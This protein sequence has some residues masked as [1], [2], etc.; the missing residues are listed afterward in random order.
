M[1]LPHSISPELLTDFIEL[2]TAQTGLAIRDQ[3]RITLSRKIWTRMNRLGITSPQFYYRLLSIGAGQNNQEWQEFVLLLTNI[4]SYFFRDRGQFSLLR[5]Q[6]LPELIDRAAK[7]KTLRIWSAGCSTGEEPYSLA[8]LVWELLGDRPDWQITILGT[9]INEDALHRAR[10]GRYTSWSFR[11]TDEAFQHKYFTSIRHHYQIN[12]KLRSMVQFRYLNLFK[13]S[14]MALTPPLEQIDLILC[15]NVFIYF[16]SGAIAKTLDKFYRSLTEG[17]YLMTG[18]AELYNQN[19]S[20]FQTKIF[21]ESV[22]YQRPQPRSFLVQ[23]IPPILPQSPLPR[24]E[25]PSLVTRSAPRQIDPTIALIAQ[26]QYLFTLKNY[27][28]ALDKAQQVLRLH[29]QNLEAHYLVAQIHAN[30]GHYEQAV[31]SC[32]RV[33]SLDPF[34]VKAYTLLAQI[35]EEVGDR[36]GTKNFLKKIIYL[37]PKSLFAY[38]ELS[39]IY[40]LEGHWQKAQKMYKATLALLEDLPLTQKVSDRE[41]LTVGELKEKIKQKLN[42]FA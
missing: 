30:T 36:E 16:E 28:V 10:C 21:P 38:W 37:E 25:K 22:I 14:F 39:Y 27:A 6:I 35:A 13:D 24:L 8:M 41:P 5:T 9:D 1:S 31:Q 2:V 19:T 32:H 20:Q 29:P 11:T 34:S 18:H 15:R 40:E 23:E 33:L 12:E 7:T 4:E 3:D 42:N 26:A 17:G